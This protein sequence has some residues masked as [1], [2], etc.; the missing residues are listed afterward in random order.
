MLP[1]H[2]APLAAARTRRG[3]LKLGLALAAGLAAP[4]ALAVPEAAAFRDRDCG[5]FPTQRKAQRFFRRQ[6]GPRED[7]HG[8]DG[9]N[10]GIACESLP[11]R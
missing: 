1:S 8:L 4:A 11:R 6:G 2:A 3:A 9:D 10:D 5:D 7:P